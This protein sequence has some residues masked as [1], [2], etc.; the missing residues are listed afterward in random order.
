MNRRPS[1]SSVGTLSGPRYVPATAVAL[2]TQH[3]AVIMTALSQAGRRDTVTDLIVRLS[4]AQ[5]LTAQDVIT[6]YVD[7]AHTGAF[8]HSRR[9]R[10]VVTE[11]DKTLLA[12]FLRDNGEGN[13]KWPPFLARV[14]HHSDK[15][16]FWKS[17][18][19]R[20][21]KDII[22]RVQTMGPVAQVQ[23][24]K[25]RAR[26]TT[27]KV[28][29]RRQH[30]DTEPVRRSSRIANNRGFCQSSTLTVLSEIPAPAPDLALRIKSDVDPRLLFDFEEVERE[31]VPTEQQNSPI[32][33]EPDPPQR[34]FVSEP[35]SP[36]LFQTPTCGDTGNRR[37]P[38]THPTLHQYRIR[39]AGIVLVCSLVQLSAEH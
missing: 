26:G 22:L 32:K 4:T 25:R 20:H 29:S 17:A 1:Q 37:S 39:S 35:A 24:A 8:V 5:G 7:Y 3:R 21:K 38:L 31:N 12:T 9:P 27:C 23:G 13:L 30:A 10:T 2:N 33:A 18:M 14:P 16:S 15:P 34:S 28:L 19:T 6:T 11:D 36:K